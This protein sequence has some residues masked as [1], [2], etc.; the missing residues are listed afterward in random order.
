MFGL[1][2]FRN[3]MAARRDY[4]DQLM[5]GFFDD[6]FLSP[7]RNMA[8]AF[9]V[10]LRETDNEYIVEAD[11]PGVKKGDITLHYENQYLT[12]AAK[13]DETQEEK[14]ENY[15]RKERRYGQFQ[16][17]LYVDNVLEDQIDATFN[18]G[19][20]SVTLPKKDKSQK[21]RSNIPIH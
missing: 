8:N 2:P 20:L 14:E 6:D 3:K 12:I 16:R 18:D 5:Q 1:V 13:R 7:V 9:R 21:R 19:V 17:S 10:D 4:L 15:V 11:L